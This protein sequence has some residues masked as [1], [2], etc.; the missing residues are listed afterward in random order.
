MNGKQALEAHK[1]LTAIE[2]AM[3]GRGDAKATADQFLGKLHEAG[4]DVVAVVPGAAEVTDEAVADVLAE[5][6]HGGRV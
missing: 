2:A 6:R 5:R 1:M 3:K 4:Y